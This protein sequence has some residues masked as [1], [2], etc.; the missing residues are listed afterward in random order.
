[1]NLDGGAGSRHIPVNSWFHLQTSLV[2]IPY[3][4]LLAPEGHQLPVACLPRIKEP[5]KDKGQRV[6]ESEARAAG[7]NQNDP[8]LRKQGKVSGSRQDTDMERFLGV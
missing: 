4:L 8:A 6:G 2:P 5:G 3:L 1:M 7:R